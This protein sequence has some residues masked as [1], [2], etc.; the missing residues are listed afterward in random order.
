MYVRIKA[1]PV[2]PNASLEV[3]S[4]VT[5]NVLYNILYSPLSPSPR[6]RGAN[7]VLIYLYINMHCY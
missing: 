7:P 3:C 2:I 6:K 1:K 5:I 4:T